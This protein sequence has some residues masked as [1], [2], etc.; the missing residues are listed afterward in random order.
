MPSSSHTSCEGGAKPADAQPL[1]ASGR[2]GKKT[3]DP[4]PRLNQEV[5]G[6]MG[7]CRFC[8][9]FARG[10]VG[11]GVYRKVIYMTSSPTSQR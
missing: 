8:A 11:L 6:E 4:P 7:V 9:A 2:G 5:W 1:L 10:V 3:V